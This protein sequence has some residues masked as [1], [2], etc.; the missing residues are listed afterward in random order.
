M[1][2][3]V[4]K[5]TQIPIIKHTEYV[6]PKKPVILYSKETSFLIKELYDRDNRLYTKREMEKFRILKSHVCIN[7]E[8]IQT[9]HPPGYLFETELIYKINKKHY[10]SIYN[11]EVNY[12]ERCEN[13]IFPLNKFK[14]FKLV[15]VNNVVD[16]NFKNNKYSFSSKINQKNY[17]K[18]EELVSNF[19][20]ENNSKSNKKVNFKDIINDKSI[21]IKKSE[22]D[23]KSYLS[24]QNYVDNRLTNSINKFTNN[25]MYN[26]HSTSSFMSPIKKYNNKSILHNKCYKHKTDNTNDDNI[27][28]EENKGEVSIYSNIK[29]IFDDDNTDGNLNKSPV[30]RNFNLSCQKKKS[31]KLEVV[32]SR[33]NKLDTKLKTSFKEHI[34]LDSI[35]KESTCFKKKEFVDIVKS[36]KNFKSDVKL[37]YLLSRDN[38]NNN[39]NNNNNI[40][41]KHFSLSTLN[42]KNID[43]NSNY[44]NNN[45]S[46][47]I[48]NN[49]LYLDIN[50]NIN[51]NSTYSNKED[52]NERPNSTKINDCKN[53]ES[54]SYDYTNKKSSSIISNIDY[55]HFKLNNYFNNDLSYFD[56]LDSINN[57]CFNNNRYKTPIHSK[58]SLDIFNKL[59][60]K[61]LLDTKTN[62]NNSLIQYNMANINTISNNSSPVN[63]QNNVSKTIDKNIEY[64]IKSNFNKK[65]INDKTDKKQNCEQLN[66]VNSKYNNSFNNIEEVDDNDINNSSRT[67]NNYNNNNK[68]TKSN[69]SNNKYDKKTNIINIINNTSNDDSIKKTEYDNY[70]A[71]K[72]NFI[73]KADNKN[74]YINLSNSDTIKNIHCNKSLELL[75]NK[76]NNTSKVSHKLDTNNYNI[77][78]DSNKYKINNKSINISLKDAFKVYI[79]GEESNIKLKCNDL[80][81]NNYYTNKFK[82]KKNNFNSLDLNLVP[83]NDIPMKKNIN[84]LDKFK[85]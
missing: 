55:N 46:N 51:N 2:K 66:S 61:S 65:S 40:D 75:S 11:S 42:Y 64:N 62:R 78:N 25:S 29:S 63:N 48:E 13:T 45:A 22:K 54:L 8:G 34:T 16:N 72:Q 70:N 56:N 30:L 76:Y 85:K 67:N 83:S 28:Q 12:H 33:K 14:E 49:T 19:R 79:F 60:K 23:N 26:V 24:N 69:K 59:I 9:F 27:N 18:F 5:K 81:H 68:E 36:C 35:K 44:N 41:Y 82:S 80:K 37:D 47:L 74:N 10:N 52:N 71:F 15:D 7:K 57:K 50:N 4:I 84:F 3:K 77:N 58:N 17:N 43:S 21:K 31:S 1:K 53:Q 6:L 32:L 38:N 73:L 39:N 20:K